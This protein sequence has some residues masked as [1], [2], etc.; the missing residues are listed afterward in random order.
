MKHGIRFLALLLLACLLLPV[1]ASAEDPW[2][3]EY[4]RAVDATG[5]LTDEEEL[6]FDGQC[7]AFMKRFRTDLA[8]LAVQTEK[9]DG[10]TLREA[11][12]D[13]YEDCG[14]GY[15]ET[16]DG[17]FLAYDAQLKHTELYAFGSAGERLSREALDGIAEALSE[18]AA[19]QSVSE[20]FTAALDALTEALSAPRGAGEVNSQTGLPAW[21]PADTERFEGFHDPDAPRVVDLADLFTDAEEQRMESRL[22]ELRRELDKDIVIYTDVTSYGKDFA[23]YAADFYDFNG[24]GIGADY[25]GVCLFVCMDPDDRGWWACATGPASQALYT[26]DNA[27]DLDD[28]LYEYMVDG[29][30]YEGVSDWIENVR[31]MYRKGIPFAPDWLPDLGAEPARTHNASAPRITDE[32]GRLDADALAALEARAAA[33]TQTCGVDVAVHVTSTTL[34]MDTGDY[35]EKFYYYNG[36]GLGENYDGILLTVVRRG[37]GDLEAELTA[38]GA[39]ADRLTEVNRKRLLKKVWN[40]MVYHEEDYDGLSRYL[41]RLDRMERT[42]RV[43]RSVGYWIFVGVLAAIAGAITG[44]VTLN[45]AKKRM[46]QPRLQGGA[47]RYQVPGMLHITRLGTTFLYRT[48]SRRYDP[49]REEKTESSSSRSSGSSHSRSSSYSSSYTSSSGRSHSGSGRKF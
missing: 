12:E 7:I 1:W 16:K 4:Y 28:V 9:Y 31:T 23:Y 42:G 36:Y 11:S 10:F 6:A 38:S 32:T 48:E 46:E 20:V 41:D 49:V 40:E 43:P 17:F 45:R 25:E 21:Y 35:A 33:I 47:A 15:G 30:Y 8:F 13:Y 39:G 44:A 26:E 29:L 3:E 22:A 18:Q 19:T 27:N 14:F 37:Y 24:Y 5:T 2:S 34:G